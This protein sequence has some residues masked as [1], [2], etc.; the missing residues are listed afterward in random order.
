[1]PTCPNC[2]R[3]LGR[4]LPDEWAECYC[5]W[6]ELG[7]DDEEIDPEEVPL[8]EISI[9]CHQPDCAI[10]LNVRHSCSCGASK[11]EPE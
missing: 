5:G 8:E 9:V 11:Q 7:E 6:S 3:E 4:H 2:D 1:M 10:S